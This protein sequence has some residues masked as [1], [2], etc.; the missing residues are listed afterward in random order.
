MNSLIQDVRFAFRQL[1]RN[2][3][4]TSGAIIVLALGIGA[5]TAML[6]VVR[7]VLLRPLSY[8]H[9][10]QLV[11]VG[12][13]GEPNTSSGVP[14]S[15]FEDMQH[16]LRSF[17]RLA[18]Y[19]SMFV[20]VETSDGTQMLLT[21]AV[22]RNFFDVL[23]VSPVLGRALRDGD[24]YC[25]VVS[26]EFWLRSMQGKRDV[27]GSKIKVNGDLYTIV[28][29]APAE[30]RFPSQ[31][32]RLWTSLQ[33][34]PDH[35]TKQGFDD[36]SVL[37]R[38][39]NKVSFEQAREEGDSFLQHKG[40][41]DG[42]EPAHFWVYP[43]QRI[44][45][46][47]E[48]PGILALLGACF[49]LMLVAVVNTANLQ[50]A[51]AAHRENEIAMRAALGATHLRLLRQL[52]VEGLMV[53]ISG[54]VLAWC[55]ASILLKPIQALFAGY[56]RMDELS[57]DPWT[58]V[59]SLTL[60][61]VCALFAT[62]APS[63]YLLQR[64]RGLFVRHADHRGSRQKLNG[65][66]VTIE[67]AL[68]CVL[69]VAAG[70]FLRTFRSLQ[71]APLG[72]V[73]DKVTT[74]LL[75]PQ[76]AI[77]DGSLIAS[78]GRVLDRLAHLRGIEAVGAVTSLPVSNFQMEADGDFSIPGHVPKQEKNG[79]QVRLVA[80][81][82]GYFTAL[83]IRLLAGR[84]LVAGDGS[85][86]QI[87]GIVN[88][89][90][91]SKFL[92]GIHPLGQQVLLNFSPPITI[93]GV[94]GDVIQGNS[95]GS[96]ARPEL[97]IS[98]QQLPSSGF[99]THFLAGI[100]A[101]FAVRTDTTTA[102]T[103]SDIKTVVAQEAPEL[104]I[105][106]IRPMRDAVSDNLSNQRMAA[107]ISSAFAWL[108]LLLAVA[109]LYGVLAYVTAHR[110]RE[111]A[112]RMALGATRWKVCALVAKQGLC[113]VA[114]G[115]ALGS[116]LALLAS[117]WIKSFLYG[118]TTHDP[119]TYAC[120]GGIMLVAALLAMFIPARRATKVDPMVALRYE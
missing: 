28:G 31:D 57:L 71:S 46:A 22:S 8:P 79:P 118:T 70:L 111:I 32:A 99:L 92:R 64:R 45:T 26:K 119:I 116:I 112:V 15:D 89:A 13:S 117:H 38:L 52:L 107:E 108:S 67:V 109:G 54:A 53:S 62:L 76:G 80:V 58:F 61:I 90:F 69:L 82:P 51:R 47:N 44:L 77:P 74:F 19:N 63:W 11:L 86:T 97:M 113:M 106:K 98:Y 55:L 105:D 37:G 103:A 9:A 93:V 81:S 27:L 114:A 48:R 10:E 83:K 96:S 2:V 120:V 33:L 17:D 95:I 84:F 3:S 35:K 56:P 20:P 23:R 6:G 7:S 68:T 29:V 115:T 110:I 14:Y 72:F 85:G 104:A 41:P 94:S 65:A 5:C 49:V 50:L 102:E 18:A 21:P 73:P 43:Y 91:V 87:V 60:A 101:S 78:Y 36:F 42:A 75:W 16:S 30:F 100:S 40:K 25:A 34:K 88:Q 39:R 1:R 59:S 4:F 66:L 12:T 24:Q